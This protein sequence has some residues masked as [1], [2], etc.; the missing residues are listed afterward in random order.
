MLISYAT[1]FWLTVPMPLIM[2][3]CIITYIFEVFIERK[4]K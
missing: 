1:L 4:G 2:V 3:I